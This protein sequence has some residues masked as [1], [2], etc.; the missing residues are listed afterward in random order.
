MARHWRRVAMDANIID[1][2]G[3]TIIRITRGA[4]GDAM[5]SVERMEWFE[6]DGHEHTGYADAVQDRRRPAGE[7]LAELKKTTAVVALEDEAL[8]D[9]A[10]GVLKT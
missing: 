8:W 10:W 7:V 9:A 5:A 3:A 6:P 4:R 1:L 2:G